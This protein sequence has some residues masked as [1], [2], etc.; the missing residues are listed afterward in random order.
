MAIGCGLIAT[1]AVILVLAG[2]CSTTGS[3]PQND[4]QKCEEESSHS[5]TIRFGDCKRMYP[6]QSGISGWD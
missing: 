3:G 6:G 2:A 4:R 5:D 1:L